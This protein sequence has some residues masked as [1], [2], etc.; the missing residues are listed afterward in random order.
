MKR[1]TLAVATV[2]AALIGVVNGGAAR[3][4][5]PLGRPT[6]TE[7]TS[8]VTE[9]TA[10]AL[11]LPTPGG[12][13]P[14]GVTELH[15]RDR[16]R[17]DPWVPT[18]DRELMISLWYP[19]TRPSARPAPYMTGAE[20]EEYTRSTGLGLPP[21]LFT[22]VETHATL[23][24]PPVRSRSGLP[25][26]ILSPGFGMP[27]ATLSGLAEELAGR[28]Y[29]VAGIG[30]NYEAHGTTFPDGRT[31]SCVACANTDYSKV[32]AVRA[33][34][35]SL[36]IDELTGKRHRPARKGGV[37]VD[38]DRIAMVGHSAGGFSFVPAMLSDARV[39][40]AVNM[41]GKY[42]HLDETPINRPVLMLGVSGRVPGGQDPTWDK[43]WKQ[44]TG[45]KRWLS[46]EGTQH[47]SFTDLAPLADQLGRPLQNTAGNRTDAITR[48]YVVSFVDAH[49]RG[50]CG[51]LLDG[52]SEHFPEVRFHRP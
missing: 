47:L 24:A 15:L 43:T 27:R 4:D 22:T 38:A 52:A 40:A 37:T 48:A 13:H 42:R 2:A 10:P 30:H 29:A 20:S 5:S 33:Q 14:I 16:G 6:T 28:G 9:E 31:T 18:S 46:V 45:W 44:L 26:V 11:A 41:D 7:T 8:T 39:K 49:L 23:D 1:A 12:E 35:V 17:A 25:L 34:D 36:V 3:A 21:G 32:G 19:A 51:H 50:R